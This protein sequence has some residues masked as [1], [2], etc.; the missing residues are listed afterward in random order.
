M[1]TAQNGTNIL[2]IK[3]LKYGLTPQRNEIG[4]AVIRISVRTIVHNNVYGMI[5]K[6]PI[7]RHHHTSM[8]SRVFDEMVFQFLI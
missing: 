3:L 1:S 5:T 2:S 6:S 8:Y 4:G 7:R